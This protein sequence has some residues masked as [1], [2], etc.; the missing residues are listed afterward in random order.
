MGFI[1]LSER[2]SHEPIAEEKPKLMAM[3]ICDFRGAED[4]QA[5][6]HTSVV[7]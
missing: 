7:A 3:Q 5:G 6:Q 4:F 1:P 2:S